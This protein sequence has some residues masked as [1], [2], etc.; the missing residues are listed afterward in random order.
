MSHRCIDQLE[1]PTTITLTS[2]PLSFHIDRPSSFNLL[3]GN[4]LLGGTVDVTTR[5]RVSGA[6]LLPYGLEVEFGTGTRSGSG[7]D[8]GGSGALYISIGLSSFN[9]VGKGWTYSDSLNVRSVGLCGSL[10]VGLCVLVGR[11]LWVSRGAGQQQMCSS[12]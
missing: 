5:G 10:L 2:T 11:H 4:V 7:I 6:I 3:L 1:A 9:N 8:L 12:L